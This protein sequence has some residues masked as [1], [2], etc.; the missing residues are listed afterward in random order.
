MYTYI[1]SCLAGFKFDGD[2]CVRCPTGFYQPLTGQF[3][4][5]PCGALQT[6]EDVG[7]TTEDACKSKARHQL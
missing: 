7:S 1:G 6:T 4:C 2:A 3:F 5:H